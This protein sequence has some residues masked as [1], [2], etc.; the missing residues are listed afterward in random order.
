[1]PSKETKHERFNRL[2]PK[3]GAFFNLLS[4]YKALDST[5][6]FPFL[7]SHITS[8]RPD[9]DPFMIWMESEKRKNKKNFTLG[10]IRTHNFR[11][12]SIKISKFKLID[13][14]HYYDKVV[15]H[16][17]WRDSNQWLQDQQAE[18]Q[19]KIPNLNM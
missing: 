15:K 3:S 17:A 4:A 13:T 18:A 8:E 16:C 11:I 2:P 10:G 1:M 14:F 19:H 7:G 5:A 9:E 6:R 12:S